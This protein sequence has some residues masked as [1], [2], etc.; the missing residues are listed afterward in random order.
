MLRAAA[1][2]LATVLGCAATPRALPSWPDAAPALRD[3]GD[4]ELATDRMWIAPLGSARAQARAPIAA[5]LAARISEALA[6]D[7]PFAAAHLLDQL[8]AL[9]QE[10]APALAAG[11]AAHAPLIHQLRTRFARAGALA[12]TVATLVVLAEL[13]PA[14]RARHTAELDEVLAFADEL[15]RAE[16]GIHAG[17]AQPI[18][19][20]QPTVATLPLPW[21]VDRY[22]ALLVGRQ[23]QVSRLLDAQGASVQ[24][25][26][27]HRDILST[28]R[29]VANVLARAGRGG[30]IHRHLARLTGIGADRELAARAEIL[31]EQP[32]ASAYLGLAGELRSDDHAADPGAALAL[33]LTALAQFPDHGEL[34]AAAADDARAAGRIDHA[35][36][37]Y[38]AALRGSE[39]VSAARG[40]RLGKLYGDRI[41]R[42]AASGRP[43]AATE[44]WRAAAAYTAA[45][46]RRQPH[47]VWQQTAAIAES[48][49]G[50]GLASIGLVDAG[51]LSLRASLARAPSIDAYETL[52]AVDL[53]VDRLRDAGRWA[54]QGIALLGDATSGDRYRRARLER[55]AADALRRGGDRERAA[56]GYLDAL[57]TWASLG[58]NKDLPP[59]IVAERMLESSRAL[60]WL[61]DPDR[62]LDHA[63]QAVEL[64]PAAPEIAGGAV[65]FLLEVGRYREALDAYHRT[66]GEPAASDTT[67]IYTSL[68]ILG[69]AARRGEPRDRLA[70]EFLAGRRGALWPEL[71]ARAASGTLPLAQLRAAATTG[72][73]RGE[74]AFYTAV[75]GLDPAAATAAG[76]RALLQRVVDERIV[77]DTE[78]DLARAYLHGDAAAARAR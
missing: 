49:L 77:L 38:E 46:A 10:D 32:T 50:K 35:I 15:A 27:A 73:Q 40:L 51:R 47:A 3:E 1:A 36:A 21:L 9:W 70:T 25:V 62:A 52:T 44:A 34:L 53:Q 60:W 20:L 4:R 55:L 78:Y 18:A 58:E 54:I 43:R 2:L 7:R 11:L 48:A 68:W 5:A 23:Q 33:E 14:Q 19:L 57:R 41:A 22:V 42:L 37:L 16:H 67:K 30:E 6:E 75:L 29:R 45:A 39:D 65:G 63:A 64:D 72:P 12:P 8:L 31:A 76:Q 13:E 24:L 56:R 69:D 71:L 61:G 26:R 74:L 66:L 28:A 17:A 59:A